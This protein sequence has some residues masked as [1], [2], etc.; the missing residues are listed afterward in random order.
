[1]THHCYHLPVYTRNTAVRVRG[2]LRCAEIHYRTRT[3]VTCFGNT[4]GF[5]VP[6]R[7]PS[8]HH[9]LPGQEKMLEKL[10]A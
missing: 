10:R 3:R 9:N 4:A 7:N 6:V 5:T 1:M 2:V 8:H